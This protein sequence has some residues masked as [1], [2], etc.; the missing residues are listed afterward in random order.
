[1]KHSKLYIE[2]ASLADYIRQ[3]PATV[4]IAIYSLIVLLV[5]NILLCHTES[6]TVLDC[7]V[8]IVL[9]AGIYLGILSL[10]QK[11]GKMVLW[12]FPF[13]ILAAFQIVLLYLYGES[14]IAVDMY[15]NVLTT[16][17]GEATELLAN[18][19]PAI[20]FVLILYIP[21]IIWA[22]V[23]WCKHKRMIS[24]WFGG[25]RRL[26][27][28]TLI[29]GIAMAGINFGIDRTFKPHIKTFPINV[30]YNIILAIDHTITSA[31]YNET[32]QDFTYHAESK[33]PA[34]SSEIYVLVIGETG[35]ALNW[36]LGGYD[37]ET[38]PLLSVRDAVSFYLHAISE[39]NIT[40]K[41]VPLLLT[42]VTAE[43]FDSLHT[44]KSIVTAFK[45]AGYRTA[46]ISNQAPNRSYTEYFSNEADTTLY[47]ENTRSGHQY[48]GEMVKYVKEIL[49]DSISKHFIVLH[50]YGSHFKYS[51]RYPAEFAQFM[52]DDCKSATYNNRPTLINAYDNTIVYTDAWLD[53]L[54]ELLSSTGKVSGM[55]YVSDHGEDIMDDS[56]K[57]F[58]H[59]SPTPTFYQLNVAML[60]WVSPAFR[61]LYGDKA[62][63]LENNTDKTVNSSASTFHTLLDMAGIE[64]PYFDNSIS[65]ASPDY[66]VATLYYLNDHN[67]PVELDKSGLKELDLKLLDSHINR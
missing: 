2:L 46:F 31:H 29:T 11:T 51:E 55:V 37:R 61:E 28:I 42:S 27:I 52:P 3:I 1:M 24:P 39:S 4:Y 10:S 65:L 64:T 8:N 15:I 21:P 67:E 43:N 38:N 13:F 47:I 33:H 14:I 5:P 48:D 34:D 12:L 20:I 62:Q 23:L 63:A 54:I 30:C 44:Q 16:N 58:L 50:S 56:R 36:Q 49:S 45:E 59:A 41:S 19:G 66:T 40:H 7:I 22:I 26:A 35:R 17:P 60:S 32:S 53:D 9:P 18:L 25:I 57:R 6:Y